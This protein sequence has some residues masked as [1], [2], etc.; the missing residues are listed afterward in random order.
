MNSARADHPAPQSSARCS[1]AASSHDSWSANADIPFWARKIWDRDNDAAR[2]NSWQGDDQSKDF[3]RGKGKDRGREKGK[4]KGREKGKEK[5]KGKGKGKDKGK[6]GTPERCQ[7]D[8]PLRTCPTSPSPRRSRIEERLGGKLPTPRRSRSRGARDRSRRRIPGRMFETG[9]GRRRASRSRRRRAGGRRRRSVI[10]DRRPRSAGRTAREDARR[11]RT[12]E[13]RRSRSAKRGPTG[14][15]SPFGVLRSV[16]SPKMSPKVAKEALKL[17]EPRPPEPT[18]QSKAKAKARSG[19]ASSYSSSASMETRPKAFAKPKADKDEPEEEE[20]MEEKE[21]KEESEREEAE[22]EASPMSEATKLPEP[23]AKSKHKGCSSSGSDSSDGSARPQSTK[24]QASQE[25]KKDKSEHEKSEE[26][27]QQDAVE[28]GVKA[29]V[30]AGEVFAEVHI[31]ADDGFDLS[32]GFLAAARE[33]LAKLKVK[34]TFFDVVD[35]EDEEGALRFGSVYSCPAKGSEEAFDAIDASD[36]PAGSSL[37]MVP[38][39]PHVPPPL[40][41]LQ[42]GPERPCLLTSSPVTSPKHG[43]G[44]EDEPTHTSPFKV[45]AIS[46]AD[47]SDSDASRISHSRPQRATDVADGFEEEPASSSSQTRLRP[48]KG[49]PASETFPAIEPLETRRPQQSLGS[50]VHGTGNC[51][52][53]AWFWRPQGCA[54]GAECGHCHL[55]SAA[56]LKARKKAKKSASQRLRAAAAAAQASPQ[57]KQ[58]P[59]VPVVA[60][61]PGPIIVPAILLQ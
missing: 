40:P 43:S 26:E 46:C 9:A 11:A 21:E 36:L 27:Q 15:R 12:T 49:F 37:P 33:Q 24:R 42:P 50:Q 57:E 48:K 31:M 13:T 34:N 25:A 53:C 38:A 16:S 58:S 29:E 19:S 44:R 60:V 45:G 39:P 55:C 10:R 7:S 54:N 1:D 18:A 14:P 4:E 35:S 28:D 32:P 61:A 41:R 8:S 47:A 20:E 30:E 51:K 2:S 52:P 5:G 22:A 17:S 6:D 23:E 3:D 59:T 56:E